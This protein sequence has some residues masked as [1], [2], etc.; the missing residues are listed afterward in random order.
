MTGPPVEQLTRRLADTPEE[1]L[2]EPLRKNGQGRVSVGAV[3]SD[4]LERLGRS[5]SRPRK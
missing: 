4:L 1:F 3:I 5:L 2:A